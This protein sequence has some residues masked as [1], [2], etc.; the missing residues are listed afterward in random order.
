MVTDEKDLSRLL[1]YYPKMTYT[2][3][4]GKEVSEFTNRYNIM[5]QDTP[6]LTKAEK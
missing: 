5:L 4:K 1:T 3:E 2:D 6:G